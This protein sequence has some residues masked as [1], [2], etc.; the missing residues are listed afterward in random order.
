MTTY[1]SLA[2]LAFGTRQTRAGLVYH[3]AHK[4]ASQGERV[5]VLDLHPFAFVTESLLRDRG[6]FEQWIENPPQQGWW[7]SETDI[8][9]LRIAEGLHLLPGDPLLLQQGSKRG[10]REKVEILLRQIEQAARNSDST[11]VLMALDFTATPWTCPALLAVRHLV[12]IPDAL[13]RSLRALPIAG[14][15]L[16]A[17]VHYGA[18]R[19]APEA[20]GYIVPRP[21]QKVFGPNDVYASC[22]ARLPGAYRAAMGLPAGEALQVDQDPYC[23]ALVDRPAGLYEL[24]S[25][26]EVPAFLLRPVHGASETLMQAVFAADRIYSALVETLRVRC[27]L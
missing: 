5:L 26:A 16:K 18:G 11:W 2:L 23:L 17:A 24:A 3:L 8:A 6:V 20:L 22:L 21:L 19:P 15:L 1:R 25:E 13:P 9:P 7:D 14:E 27:G 4:L 12:L 10:P